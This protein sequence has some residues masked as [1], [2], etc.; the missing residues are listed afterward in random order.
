M[1]E[2]D[3][4]VD[5]LSEYHRALVDARLDRIRESDHF[6]DSRRISKDLYELRWANGIRVYYSKVRDDEGM[7]ALLLFGG[8]KNGQQKDIKKA[9]RICKRE[10]S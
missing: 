4:W 3:D 9:K 7:I 5:D 1:P 6:G 8:N 10:L 2:Y